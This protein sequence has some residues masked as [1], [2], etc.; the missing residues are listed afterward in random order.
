MPPW[1]W[2]GGERKRT[3]WRRLFKW[4]VILLGTGQ[5]AR[6][7]SYNKIEVWLL[8]LFHI[9][10][11]QTFSLLKK[12]YP[13]CRV[14]IGLPVTYWLSHFPGLGEMEAYTWLRDRLQTWL[15]HIPSKWPNHHVAESPGL[16][17]ERKTLICSR[18]LCSLMP[19]CCTDTNS[20]SELR[21]SSRQQAV[22]AAAQ[23]RQFCGAL[24][25]PG[26]AKVGCSSTLSGPS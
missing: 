15:S 18:C 6:I 3:E 23:N 19:P 21:G 11:T 24:P 14:C 2:G 9:R 25:V 5:N 17:R 10:K 7:L 4:E 8:V 1:G 26:K 20:F 13:Q 16:C 22:Q 12:Q